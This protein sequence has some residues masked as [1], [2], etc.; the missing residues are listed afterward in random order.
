MKRIIAII[1]AL[2][3]VMSL[4]TTAF[5][6]ELD[7]MDK[8]Y[9]SYDG[10]AEFFVEL[11]K[12]LEFIELAN[13]EA[14]FDVKYFTENLLKTKITS[15]VQA[16]VSPELDKAKLYMSFNPNMPIY[17]S[18]DLKFNADV[19]GH[20]WLEYD[21]SSVENA[22]MNVIFKNPL[23][24]KYIYINYFDAFAELD[25]DVNEIKAMM[26]ESFKEAQS[27][28]AVELNAIVKNEYEKNA[29]IKKEGSVVTLNFTNNSLIDALYGII[30]GMLKSDYMAESMAQSGV[31]LS[32]LEI[33]EN[34][35]SQIVTFIKGLGIFGDTDAY[36]YKVK[37]NK[38]GYITEG[39]ERM[40]I[41]F[42]LFDTAIALGASSEELYPLTSE[43]TDIDLTLCSKVTYT[44][45]NEEN[46]VEM[47]TLTEENSENLLEALITDNYYEEDTYVEL[48]VYQSEKFWNNA[49]GM[50]DR[51]GMYVNMEGFIDSCYWDEDNLTGEVIL[52]ED[53]AVEITLTSDNFGTV[54]VKGNVHEDAY[55]LNDMQLWGRKPF[56]IVNEYNWDEYAADAK[57]YVNMD[58]LNYILGAK[59]QSVTTYI[60]DD[61]G[62]EMTNPEYYFHIV[63]PNPG[64]VEVN[65]E[66]VL[67]EMPEFPPIDEM[68][69]IGIIGGADGPTEVFITE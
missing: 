53:G 32:D 44:K 8:T 4:A 63:R 67:G 31:E 58:V 62:I 64:Y 50:M 1:C 25:V 36:T 24:G 37:L 22:K 33:D 18:E 54:V 60:L 12:P 39:E 30:M 23:N 66:D 7:F 49:K 34:E 68:S 15:K 35:I 3:M 41:D 47:P 28:D 6:S 57:L 48:E 17:I 56:K 19:T 59:V 29:D 52:G 14:G 26:I 55:T 65:Y 21:F 5:A 10:V 16:E 27:V 9:Y 40:H 11:N 69:A 43:N 45:I 51:G 42:N 2:A 61:N 46:V 20:M 38:D 13:E